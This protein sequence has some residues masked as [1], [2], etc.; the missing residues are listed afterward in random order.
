MITAWLIAIAVLFGV[1]ALTITYRIIVG[2]TILDRVLASDVL[3]VMLVT[4]MGIECAR[5][6]ST[7]LFAPM[8]VVVLVGFIGTV[9]IGR[10]V[11]REGPR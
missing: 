11:A 8:L 7:W 5:S 3:V 1:S 4:L 6:G 9:A 2:P 10:F